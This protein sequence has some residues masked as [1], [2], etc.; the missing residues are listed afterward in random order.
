M[1]KTNQEYR[2]FCLLW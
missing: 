2:T 1:Q